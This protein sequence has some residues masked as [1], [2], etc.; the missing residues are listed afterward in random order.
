MYTVHH[1]QSDLINNMDHMCSSGT[2]TSS[3]ILSQTMYAP[4]VSKQAEAKRDGVIKPSELQFQ[5][6]F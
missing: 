1:F 3:V 4:K 2:E 6:F 5:S